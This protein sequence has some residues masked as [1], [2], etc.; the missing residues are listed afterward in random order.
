MFPS[1]TESTRSNHKTKFIVV[2]GST[3]LA[4]YICGLFDVPSDSGR[5]GVVLV[6]S[7]L[8]IPTLSLFS[9]AFLLPL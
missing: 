2:N 3:S 5:R 9:Y 7:V 8:T 6:L 4:S 1:K